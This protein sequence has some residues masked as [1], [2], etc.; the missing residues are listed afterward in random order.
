MMSVCANV[1]RADGGAGGAAAGGGGGDGNA[2]VRVR[3]DAAFGCV[4]GFSRVF[5]R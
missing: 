3:A 5:T 4:F 1:P 2:V